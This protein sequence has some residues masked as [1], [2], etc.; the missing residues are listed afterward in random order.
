M[1]QKRVTY[2]NISD[3]EWIELLTA[4]P[5]DERACGY[6]F[7][8]KC[9]F[10]LRYIAQTIFDGDEPASLIGDFYQYLSH[11]NWHV[12]RLFSARN[13][14]SLG[15]Y[16]SRCAINYFKAQKVSE[17]KI[18]PLWIERPDIIAELNNFTQE[19]EC[20]TPPV[21]QAYKRLNKRDQDIL[22]LLVINN[23]SALEAAD[24][25]W[26]QVKSSTKDWRLLPVKR[27]QDTIAMLKRR[28]LLALAL[29]LR[30]A[31]KS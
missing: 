14:A 10:F 2:S 27:V 4:C 31:T 19:E 23:K 16:L 17:N 11:N 9:R 29:E 3:N 28:A 7:N 8:V 30:G 25:I 15:S 18:R 12:L 1:L 5:P 22:R 6:F 21:W 24:E 26:P 20:D 13:G